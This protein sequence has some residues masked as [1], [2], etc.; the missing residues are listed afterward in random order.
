VLCELAAALGEETGLESA[1]EVLAAIAA[2]AGIYAGIT[3]EEI[4]GRGIRWQERGE[5]VAALPESRGAAREYAPGE[6]DGSAARPQTF[7]EHPSGLV[8][9]TYR[10][11]WA[12]PVT[13]LNPPLHFL[14]PTQRLEIATADAQRL[15]IA[16]GDEVTVSSNG[17]SVSALAAVR[18]RI[19]AGTCFL[20]EGTAK[21]NANALL[22]GAPAMV[23]VEKAT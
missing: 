18:E 19:D 4:G 1:P 17:S 16:D 8:L 22:N 9:G 14:T 15:A 2:E 11:L 13:E 20:I 23:E 21:D 12:S 5:A 3:P 10:D 6:T 7:G